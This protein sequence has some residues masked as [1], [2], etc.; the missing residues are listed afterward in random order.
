MPMG[1][2]SHFR[3]VICIEMEDVVVVAKDNKGKV[4]LHQAVNLNAYG[5]GVSIGLVVSF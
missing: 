4:K 5:C 2:K 3:S 1:L